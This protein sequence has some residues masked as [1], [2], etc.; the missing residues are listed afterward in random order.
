VKQLIVMLAAAA[1]SN[2]AG[3]SPALATSGTGNQNPTVTLTIS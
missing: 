2:L 3:I 1:L